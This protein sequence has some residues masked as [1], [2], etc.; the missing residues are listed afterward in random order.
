M[1]SDIKKPMGI[2]IIRNKDIK[3]ILFKNDVGTFFGIGKSTEKL[4][5]NYQI[6]TIG[7]L[8]DKICHVTPTAMTKSSIRTHNI[9]TKMHEMQ[10]VIQSMLIEYTFMRTGM[11]LFS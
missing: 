8:Y 7:Q 10:I 3:E 4:L 9:E 6:T 1:A 11:H 2:T 5:K